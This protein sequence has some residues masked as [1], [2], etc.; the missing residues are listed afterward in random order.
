MSCPGPT[1][2]S[3]CLDDGT[4]Q[5]VA[6][7]ATYE[8]RDPD[9]RLLYVIGRTEPDSSGKKHFPSWRPDPANP[10]RYLMGLGEQPRVLYRLPE[11]RR[12]V[13]AGE[14]LYLVEGEKDAENLAEA[15][16]VCATSSP[17]GAGSWRDEF[18]AQLRGTSLAVIV[19]DNDEPGASHAATVAASLQG[20]EI[21]NVIL[22]LPELPEKGDISDWLTAGGT[23]EEL[24]RLVA[25]AVESSRRT[26]TESKDDLLRSLAEL[27]ADADLAAIEAALRTIGEQLVGR[28]ELARA[29]AREAIIAELKSRSISSPA[30]LADACLGPPEVEELRPEW[31]CEPLLANPEPWPE[32]VE[33]AELLDRMV[34]ALERFLVLAEG[35][36][37]ALA[38]W[39]LFSHC[40]ASFFVSPRLA[41]CSPLRRCGKTNT[42]ALLAELVAAPLPLCNISAA[43]VFRTIDRYRPTLLIDEAETFLGE[44]EELRGI[45]N[46]GHTRSSAYVLRLVGEEHEPRRFSTFTPIAFALIGRLPSTLEDR[47][48]VLPMRRRAAHES[49]ERLR[50][51]RLAELAP[52]RRQAAR[53]AA[54]AA[55]ELAGA[56]PVLPP[57][58]SDRAADNWRPL[59]AIA[60]AAGGHWP[61]RARQALASLAD[62][63]GSEQAD[64]AVQLLADIEA[65]FADGGQERLSS[66]EIVTRLAAMEDRPWP[67]WSRRGPISKRQLALLLSRFSIRPKELRFGDLTRRGYRRESF[68][69]AFARYLPE[70]T[71]TSPTSLHEPGF[72]CDTAVAAV[73]ERIDGPCSDVSLVSDRQSCWELEL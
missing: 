47:S 15:C 26:P 51:D 54:D 39:A 38:L 52:L 23:P 25:V 60:D 11:L 69:D 31:E 63:G 44:N 4:H 65:I 64:A 37:A 17:H 41:L 6:V 57:L 67:E 40:S 55:E 22:E 24:E 56:D 5:R 32:E 71:E 66:E 13:E 20:A 36:P 61:S 48:I 16:G 72:G 34:A 45:L 21:P 28:D 62:E 27:P 42:M 70:R 19:P 50:L 9:G 35:A 43:G 53:W 14:R 68:S 7:I 46:S 1:T 49:V 30:R 73:G 12:A 33:G 58:E 10:H 18:A 8:Y 2:Y 29:M 3:V 59:L